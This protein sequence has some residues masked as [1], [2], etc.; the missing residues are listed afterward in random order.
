MEFDY[1]RTT[2]LDHPA[3][4]NDRI[5]LSNNM[6]AAPQSGEIKTVG[7]RIVDAS[8]EDTSSARENVTWQAARAGD[9]RNIIFHA[10]DEAVVEEKVIDLME[11]EAKTFAN[12]KTGEITLPTTDGLSDAEQKAV[13]ARALIEDVRESER[14]AEVET[15]DGLREEL[16][17][18]YEQLQQQE[19]ARAALAQLRAQ[20]EAL[21]ALVTP[22]MLIQAQ[23]VKDLQAE[24]QMLR[25]RAE[26][27][28]R[29]MRLNAGF[30]R[31]AVEGIGLHGSY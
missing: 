30:L 31:T 9:V 28:A 6:T 3:D 23:V 12:T 7:F 13:L 14:H 24:N 18:V 17:L 8:V 2:E 21:Q 11:N 16:E 4:S 19:D 26:R 27:P 29:T 1:P 10:D 25:S 20:Y 22:D 15:I 5:E